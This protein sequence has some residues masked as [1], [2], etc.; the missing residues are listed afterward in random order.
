MIPMVNSTNVAKTIRRG[1]KFYEADPGEIVAVYRVDVGF[2]LT[3]GFRRAYGVEPVDLEPVD[4]QADEPQ[5]DEP[6]ADEPTLRNKIPDTGTMNLRELKSLAAAAGIEGFRTMNKAD[7]V[8]AL[9]ND[10]R[11]S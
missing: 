10:K 9:T 1:P 8:S 4:P 2:M 6:Q 11:S 3:A 7:L 5:A